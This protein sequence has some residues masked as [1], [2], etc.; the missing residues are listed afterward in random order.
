[1]MRRTRNA[2]ATLEL[3]MALPVI[4]VM[5]VALVWL[6]YS[7]IGQATA[8]V[9][10]RHQSF[11]QRFQP[12]T[13]TAFAFSDEQ[14]ITEQTTESIEVS[15]LL[16]GF[17]D[18]E[19]SHTVQQ[20]NWDHRSVET[21]SLPHWELYLE[22]AVASKREGLLSSYQDARDLF[23]R[24]RGFGRE[25]LAEAVRE[26]SISLIDPGIRFGSDAEVIEDR[27][28]LEESLEEQR[29]QGRVDR[30]NKQIADQERLIER[31]KDDGQAED[32]LWLAEQKLTRLEI[33]LQ[34]VEKS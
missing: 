4:L 25:A 7:V 29:K 23:E 28:E 8:T 16:D 30:L 10:S 15:P 14:T 9:D 12:W 22:L 19:S 33:I 18:P 11:S 1:M 26:A 5:L 13:Q 34:L 27:L 24:L 32:R 31:L 17:G 3:V 6:G 20:G 21:D 2:I